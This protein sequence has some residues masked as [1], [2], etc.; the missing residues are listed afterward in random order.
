LNIAVVD[1]D[2]IG[3]ARHRFPNL[4]CMKISGYH[5]EMGD[6]VILKTDYQDLDLFD[7]VYIS[8]VFTDTKF[9]DQLLGAKNIEYGGTGFFYDKAPSL[10]PK[11]EHHKPDYHLY[12]EWSA[13][14]N[15]NT[16]YYTEYSLGYLTRH[17][18]RGCFFCVNKNYRAVDYHADLEEFF[19]EER[20]SICLLDDNF[21]GYK[22]WRFLLGKLQNTKKT[23]QFKQGLDIRLMTD[24][25][26]EMLSHS[27]YKGDYI[28][29]FDKISERE[30]IER[31]LKV[32]RNYCTKNTKLYTF[33]GFKNSIQDVV[34]T[35]ERIKIL[36][37]YGCFPYIM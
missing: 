32:W 12:D 5:K 19:D 13:S 2:L 17:C 30:I 37:K 34:D 28:F 35:F 21:L 14:H 29:A 33:C 10:P 15:D 16:E 22:D 1:A 18:F 25:K 20:K 9:D 3:R 8:K 23:F 7:K 11:I 24:E 6:R 36:M 26:A 4:C 31:K 27:R